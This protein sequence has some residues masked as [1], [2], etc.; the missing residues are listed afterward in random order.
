[1]GSFLSVCLSIGKKQNPEINKMDILKDATYD[2]TQEFSL[3]G[4]NG[5]CKV[6]KIYDGDT[7]HVAMYINEEMKRIKCRL[8]GID[9][10]EIKGDTEEERIL[11]KKSKNRLDDLTKNKFIWIIVT[12]VDKYGRYLATFYENKPANYDIYVENL[13]KT[14]LNESINQI[15]LDEKLAYEYTGKTKKKFNE[16][17]E[18]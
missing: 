10:P 13:K 8:N 15:L 16:W 1:M 18:K 4:I 7:I 9:A 3:K 6:V 14:D 5:L 2:S 11:A 12:G 17:H